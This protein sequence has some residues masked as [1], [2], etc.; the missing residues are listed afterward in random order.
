M[1]RPDHAVFERPTLVLEVPSSLHMLAIKLARFAGDTDRQDATELLKRLRPGYADA[2]DLWT[3]I[4]GLAPRGA[5]RVRT[6]QFAQ[7]LGRLR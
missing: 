6:L 3:Q 7:D 1:P 2:D 5:A 4:G